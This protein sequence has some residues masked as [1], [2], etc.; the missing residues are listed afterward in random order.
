MAIYLKDGEVLKESRPLPIPQVCY[1]LVKDEVERLVQ[2][3]LV[4]S[5]KE[6]DWSSPSFSIPKKTKLFGLTNFK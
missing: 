5:I 2:I 1:E 4:T 3:G 6:V